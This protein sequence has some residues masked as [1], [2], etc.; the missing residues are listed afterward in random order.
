MLD[1]CTTEVDAAWDLWDHDG[2]EWKLA[3]VSVSLICFA[4]SFDTQFRRPVADRILLDARFLP[5]P[6]VEGA[7]RI[8]QSNI[9]SLLHLVEEID[10]V[11][12]PERRTLWSESGANLPTFCAVFLNYHRQLT[13]IPIMKLL[14]IVFLLGVARAQPAFE[15]ASL[16]PADPDLGSR[17]GCHG[18]DSIYT[19]ANERVSAP[20]LGRCVITGSRLSHMIGMAFRVGSMSYIKGGPEWV[21]TGDF[22]YTVDAK[23]EDP[24]KTNEE[25]LLQMLQGLLIERFNL[26]FHRETREIPGYTLVVAKNGPKL[27]ASKGEDS[28]FSWGATGKPGNGPACLTATK[29]TTSKLATILTQ[30]GKGPALDRT[31]LTGEYD[32][33]LCWNETDGPSLFSALQEQLGLKFEPQKVPVSFFIVDSAQKPTE[34]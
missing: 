3:P 23:A 27:P 2:S 6:G 7:L 13:S 33:K 29:W 1:D 5:T 18:I 8:G 19:G 22:R 9:R 17:G 24:T 25:Q 32:F 34:N 28:G 14:S 20:P 30:M 10:R 11:M 12:K 15:V 31:G 21:A 26:K 4:P 16:N